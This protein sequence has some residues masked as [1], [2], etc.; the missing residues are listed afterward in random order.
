MKATFVGHIRIAI[1]WT[2]TTFVTSEN[3]K[4]PRVKQRS[5]KSPWTRLLRALVA[6]TV[7]SAGVVWFITWYQ[8]ERP[9]HEIEA[10]LKKGQTSQAMNLVSRFLRANPQDA[11]GQSIRA[12]I[13]VEAGQLSDALRLFQR[14]GASDL[15]G[16]HAWAKA[17]LLRE[18]WSDALPVLEQILKFHPDD[19]DALHEITA[20]RSFLGQYRQ[21]FESAER[22]ALQPGNE[23]RAWLQMGTLHKNLGN[24]HSAVEAWEQVLKYDPQIEKLQIRASDFLSEYG[25]VLLKDGQP[26]RARDVLQR[27]LKLKESAEA[28]TR[29]GQALEQL[30]DI[31]GAIVR[32]KRAVEMAPALREPRESLAQGAFRAGRFDEARAWLQPVLQAP[33]PTSSA[34]YLMQRICHALNESEAAQE[35]RDRTDRLRKKEKL[36]AA[37]EHVLIEAPESNW[38]RAIRAYQFAESGNWHQAEIF[39][40]ALLEE[41]IHEPFVDKLAESIRHKGTLPPLD[42]IPIHQF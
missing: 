28:L 4:S 30:D 31:S 20:C 39:T 3:L 34:A 40:L 15:A 42:L 36:Q 12:R 38:A 9:L 16:L 21:A 19:P 7:A 14:S 11:R 1:H 5:S 29:L 18:E 41:N 25:R 35:W 23:A 6:V 8:H 10:A 33:K 26:E 37:I 27:S 13:L 24:D 17:H 32:W 22:L 2:E